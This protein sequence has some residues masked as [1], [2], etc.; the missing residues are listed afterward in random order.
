MKG[1]GMDT[2]FHINKGQQRPLNVIWEIP[3]MGGRLTV[4]LEYFGG[5]N[6]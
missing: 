1:D 2:Y 5:I 6:K 3:V 4:I